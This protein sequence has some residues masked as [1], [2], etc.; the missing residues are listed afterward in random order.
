MSAF[1][2]SKTTR[3]RRAVSKAVSRQWHRQLVRCRSAKCVSVRSCRRRSPPPDKR[4]EKKRE[5]ERGTNHAAP[6]PLPGLPGGL[7][8]LAV[9]SHSPA[10]R[11]LLA[12]WAIQSLASKLGTASSLQSLARRVRTSGRLP[13]Q[14]VV[15]HR[16]HFGT[17]RPARR[18]RGCWRQDTSE[19]GLF[20]YVSGFFF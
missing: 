11:R 12:S 2:S 17:A 15:H 20:L 13:L 14:A 3:W 16:E 4:A 5:R 1:R 6:G 8:R 7:R 9:S 19:G 10:L 18:E